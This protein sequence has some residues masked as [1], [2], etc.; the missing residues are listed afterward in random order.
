MPR[1]VALII[2]LGGFLVSAV[3]SLALDPDQDFSGH[4]VLDAKASTA[5]SLAAPAYDRLTVEQGAVIQ[6][7]ASGAD[8]SR[9]QWSYALDRKETRS[10][11]AGETWSSVAKWEGSALLINTLLS[12][13][14]NYTVMDRWTLSKDRSTLRVNRQ[15]LVAAKETEG[16]LIYHRET[17]P[18]TLPTPAVSKLEPPAEPTAGPLARRPEP[19]V[20]NAP[21][22]LVRRPEPPP[23]PSVPSTF[24]V[25]AG[26]RIPL[27]LRNALDTKHSREGDKVYLETLVPVSISDHVV[28][29]RGSSVN[30]T[31]VLSKPAGTVKGKGELRIR[32]DTLILPNGTTR[33]FQSQVG[34][35]DAG[36]GHVDPKEGTITGQRDKSGDAK[37]TAEGAGIGA[38]VGGL[39]GVAAGHPLG[40]AGIGAAAGAAA[41]LA[42]AL[43]KHRPDVTLPAGTTIEMVLDRDLQ[44]N[45][46]ELP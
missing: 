41:G 18:D 1:S 38:G 22:A 8:G 5:Q 17:P 31:L 16:V 30:G 42:A 6:C 15:V 9:V 32:F 10:V 13:A 33:D 20:R 11:I 36:S 39:A 44:F 28:I 26:T 2:F 12:G 46:K 23:Q 25:A 37:T 45:S 35:A 43:H 3:P 29:P 4:W 7:T 27:S 21:E 14:R 40:G 34:S 19:A 24:N